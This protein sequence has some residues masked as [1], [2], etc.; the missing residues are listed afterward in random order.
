MHVTLQL[1][2]NLNTTSQTTQ[3][4]VSSSYNSDNMVLWSIHC[5]HLLDH[6]CY[7]LSFCIY[8]VSDLVVVFCSWRRGDGYF[9]QSDSLSYRLI[10]LL[11][12]EKTEILTH[13]APVKCLQTRQCLRKSCAKCLCAQILSCGHTG[14]KCVWQHSKWSLKTTFHVVFHHIEKM[15]DWWSPFI[16]IINRFRKYS[17]KHFQEHVEIQDIY[18][19][20]LSYSKSE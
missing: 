6:G 18:I 9:L 7:F 4:F 17:W 12:R 13:T 14:Y 16:L 15:N 8:I 20:P 11:F 3:R 19:I 1:L 10:K 2:E 5:A